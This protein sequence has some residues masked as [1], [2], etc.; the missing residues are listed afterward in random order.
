MIGNGIGH[1]SWWR[2]MCHNMC[3]MNIEERQRERRSEH[4]DVSDVQ[5]I[6]NEEVEKILRELARI[7]LDFFGWDSKLLNG[8]QLN[9]IK[10]II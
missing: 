4:D 2:A 5:K 10:C 3:S 1:R 8:L 9:R 7:S 6:V